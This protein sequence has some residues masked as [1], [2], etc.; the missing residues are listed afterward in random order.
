M[1]TARV[2]AREALEDARPRAP[3]ES[4]A[5]LQAALVGLESVQ[6]STMFAGCQAPENL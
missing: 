3:T 1:P 6:P 4:Q 5:D 2:V